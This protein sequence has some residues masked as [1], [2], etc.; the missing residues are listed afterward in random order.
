MARLTQAQ[1]QKAR[2]LKA[3]RTS[4]RRIAQGTS[5]ALPQNQKPKPVEQSKKGIKQRFKDLVSKRVDTID[6]TV[7]K[8]TRGK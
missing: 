2:G 6:K 5:K 7:K 1:K 3:I 8:A 4:E